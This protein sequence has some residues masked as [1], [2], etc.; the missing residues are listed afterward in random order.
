MFM[1][2]RHFFIFHIQ[3]FYE[4]ILRWA[5]EISL[6]KTSQHAAFSTPGTTSISVLQD[7]V[8]CCVCWFLMYLMVHDFYMP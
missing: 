2:T 6:G 3:Y 4:Y 8:Q 7:I 1:C 5:L